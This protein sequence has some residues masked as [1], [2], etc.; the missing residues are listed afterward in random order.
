MNKDEQYQFCNNLIA[1]KDEIEKNFLVLGKGLIAV[2]DERLYIPAW[3]SFP[4]YCEELKLS[5]SKASKLISIYSKFVVAF[6]IPE[7]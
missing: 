3:N 4:E 5:E 1:L 7:V 2:R 6:D